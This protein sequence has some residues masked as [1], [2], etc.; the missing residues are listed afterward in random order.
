MADV[1]LADPCI[2]GFCFFFFSWIALIASIFFA[3]QCHCSVPL[4]VADVST[5]LA[6]ALFLYL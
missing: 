6:I 2:F 4:P 3:R 5:P 1:L